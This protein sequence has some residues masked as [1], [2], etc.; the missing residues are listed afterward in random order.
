MPIVV[1]AT[2]VVATVPI[3]G[4]TVAAGG[5][6]PPVTGITVAVVDWTPAPAVVVVDAGSA[7]VEA[8]SV[9]AVDVTAAGMLVAPDTIWPAPDVTPL[10][11]VV[12]TVMVADPTTL[13]PAMLTAF[14]EEDAEPVSVAVDVAGEEAAVGTMPENDV[15]GAVL[16]E[17]DAEPAGVLADAAAEEIAEVA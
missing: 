7:G 17:E 11:G 4:A 13:L 8:A 2:A 14:G 1:G 3:T 10:G 15:A 5:S 16:A 6:R 12:P 9:V